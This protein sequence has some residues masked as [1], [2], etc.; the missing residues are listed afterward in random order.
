MFA[1]RMSR[2]RL[3]DNS[4]RN[5]YKLYID[6]KARI[7]PADPDTREWLTLTEL[8]DHTSETFRVYRG[9]LEKRR[10]IVAKIG[11]PDAMM[12]EIRVAERLRLLK[13][14]TFMT[15]LCTFDCLDSF[16]AL[17][18]KTRSLCKTSGDTIQVVLMDY[19]DG[20]SLEKY[21]WSRQTFPLLIN[22]LKHLVS[23]LLVASANVGFV[24][25]DLHLGNVLL[26]R[27]SRMSI[28]YEDYELDLNGILPVIMDYD[29]STIDG[30]PLL[31]Y[32][33]IKKLCS[34]VST[35]FDIQLDVTPVLLLCDWC[36]ST[37]KKPSLE[38]IP[39]FLR[40][41]ERISIRYVSSEISA[42]H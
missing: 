20:F 12:N 39:L 25:R 5:N 33:D 7:N 10:K 19:I 24:H 18:D 40:Q 3:V 35:M 22:V 37:D 8:F 11:R 13:L 15:F 30:N 26:K 4:I 9:L 16:K 17:S 42:R 29:R 1:N 28:H 36:V 34:L 32:T 21:P 38:F 27:T 2:S 23:S 6:C 31:I 14:P 41:I